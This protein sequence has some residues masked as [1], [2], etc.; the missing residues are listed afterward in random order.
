MDLFKKGYSIQ[1]VWQRGQLL[2]CEVLNHLYK[3]A[4]WNLFL[5]V[6]QAN[7]GRALLEA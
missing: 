4:E 3:H 6:L 2:L 7:L 1:G 5:H